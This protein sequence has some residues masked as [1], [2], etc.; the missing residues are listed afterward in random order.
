MESYYADQ[1]KQINLEDIDQKN[2]QNIN[3]NINQGIDQK[4]FEILFKIL[5]KI[6]SIYK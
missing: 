2:I 6:L 5:F 1:D 3:Q 4:T